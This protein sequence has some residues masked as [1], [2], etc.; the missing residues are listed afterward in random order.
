LNIKNPPNS[1]CGPTPSIKS[2]SKYES[3]SRLAISSV[4]PNLNRFWLGDITINYTLSALNNEQKA[5]F[6]NNL[7]QLKTRKISFGFSYVIDNQDESWKEMLEDAGRYKPLGIRASLALPG[8]SKQISCLEE[9]NDMKSLSEKTYQLQESCLNLGIP[10]FFYRP[11]PLC[12][13]S[14]P[15]WQKLRSLFPFLAFTRCPIG[16][17]GDYGLMVVV[18]PDLSVF[19]CTSLFIQ[20]PNI[21]TFK[22][23]LKISQF[24]EAS[25]KDSLSKPLMELCRECSAHKNFFIK[26]MKQSQ[27]DRGICQGGCLNFRSP[28]Q[29]LCHVE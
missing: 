26:G 22:D 18:N 5:L 28:I 1:E 25:V 23:R 20:G 11:L 8:F 27:F 10:F 21:L 17:K 16:Y 19:P 4:L 12:M 29:S 14:Q 2:H 9:F 6:R 24:Y 3:W 15:G 13:L 7:E